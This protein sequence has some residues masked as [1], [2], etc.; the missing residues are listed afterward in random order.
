MWARLW[1]VLSWIKGGSY[2]KIIDAIFPLIFENPATRKWLGSNKRFVGF[3]LTGIGG[4]LALACELYQEYK[5]ICDT[6][7]PI[8]TFASGWILNAIGQIHAASKKR[9]GLIIERK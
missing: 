8:Y 2:D 3:V 6:T 9:R 5:P 1:A 7:I 4:L